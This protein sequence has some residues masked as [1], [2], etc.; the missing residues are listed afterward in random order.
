MNLMQGISLTV[1][2]GALDGQPHPLLQNG[3][4]MADIAYMPVDRSTFE[5]VST[6]PDG[7]K[8]IAR[9]TFSEDGRTITTRGASGTVS[10]WHK[11]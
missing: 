3:I 1:Y 11:Q 2:Q 10:V 8:A 4:K 9:H 7:K 5:S 6:L